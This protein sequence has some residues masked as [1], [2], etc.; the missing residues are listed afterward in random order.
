MAAAEQ[1]L[2]QL[3]GDIGGGLAL[4]DDEV[5]VATLGECEHLFLRRPRVRQRL[6]LQLIL[7]TALT[8][9]A[10][11]LRL[12]YLGEQQTRAHLANG[13][14]DVVIG[15]RARARALPLLRPMPDARQ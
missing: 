8:L 1:Y 10:G 9:T 4:R 2:R 5:G 12:E 6:Q 7:L 14:V 11:A 3:V 13:R 15:A